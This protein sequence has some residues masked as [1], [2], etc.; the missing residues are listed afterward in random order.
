[1]PMWQ[2]VPH[3]GQWRRSFLCRATLHAWR[4]KKGLFE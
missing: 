2:Q 3:H 1:M 4:Y